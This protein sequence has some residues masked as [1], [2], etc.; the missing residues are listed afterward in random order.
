MAVIESD[1]LVQDRNN[2]RSPAT[3]VSLTVNN[4]EFKICKLI[5]GKHEQ[6]KMSLILQA[7]AN[8][9]FK[10]IGEKPATVCLTGYYL[11]NISEEDCGDEACCPMDRIADDDATIGTENNLSNKDDEVSETDEEVELPKN[12]PSIKSNSSSVRKDSESAKKA[13]TIEK[14][15]QPTPEDSRIASPVKE[16]NGTAKKDSTPSRQLVNKCLPN[17]LEIKDFSLGNGVRAKKGQRVGISYKGKLM[18]N[19]IFEETKG[20]DIHYFTIGKREVIPGLD[21]GVEGMSLGGIRRLQVPSHLGYGEKS[22]K[23]VPPNSPL[24]FEV[25]LVKVNTKK[26]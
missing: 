18:N 22:Q 13:K 23:N 7:G 1:D 15:S 19:T 14:H 8:V 16:A 25:K 5:P 3:S 21:L 12:K 24:T 26:L 17:G 10:V 11:E 4:E 9:D 6:Q 20:N 2:S